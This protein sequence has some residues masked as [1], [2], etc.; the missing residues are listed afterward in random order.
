M[1]TNQPS[2]LSRSRPKRAVLLKSRQATAKGATFMMMSM[3]LQEISK[4]ACKTRRNGAVTSGL[5]SVAATPSRTAKNMRCSMSGVS[6]C[7]SRRADAGDRGDGIGRD[8][9]LDHLHQGG[10]GRG[11][12]LGGVGDALGGVAAV[13]GFEAGARLGIDAFAGADG[14]R[15]GDADDDRDRGDDEGVGERFQADAAELADIADAG[16]ADDERREHERDDDHQ[17]QAKEERADRLGDIRDGPD[18][19][20]IVAAEQA[21]WRRRRR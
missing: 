17:Q 8:E 16:D 18:D 19:A 1:T 20:R 14:V 21:C 4:S 2:A 13:A 5:T 6:V 15:D 12:F 9:R 7:L 3:I 10:V 11:G